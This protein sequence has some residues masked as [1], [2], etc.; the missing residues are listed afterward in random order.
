MKEKI[1][2]RTLSLITVLALIF[3]L[4]AQGV[5]A[6][7]S[8]D[9]NKY[10]Y[11]YVHGLFGW[12]EDEGIDDTLPYWGSASCSLMDEMN[13]RHYESYAAS[14]GPVSSNWDR[15][16][17]LYAQITGTRVDYGAA[18][19]AK[20]H[21][22]RYGRTYS[23]LMIEGWGEPDADGNIKK[24]NLI[25]H[26]FGGAA[27]RTLTALLEYGSA[28]EQAAT[29]PEDI[30]PLFTGGK[31][32][33]INSVTTL[34]APHNGTTLTYIA[35]NMNLAE[36]G[37]AACYIYAGFMGR[38]KLN[39]YVDF[40]LEQFGLTRIPGDDSTPEEVFIKA[41]I[42]VM[43][44]PDNAMF[45]MYPERAEEINE[46]AKPV[47]GVYYFSY[48]YQT[49]RKTLV[50]TQVPMAR[51]LIVLRPMANLIGVY[52]R[53]LDTNYKIDAS[54]LPNDGLVNVISAR[55]PFTDAHEDYTAN[56]ELQT[57]KWYV[58]P[59]HEGDH[60]TVIGMQ[61]TKRQTLKFY[62]ELTDLIESLPVTD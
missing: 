19:S 2:K 52:S 14:V 34:C 35:D 61:C 48:S 39:G 22:S 59:T 8:V 10:P 45:D 17:E 56:A 3:T 6:I 4:A 57:G 23:E 21:H 20:Y 7:G 9:I 50:G 54:W 27:V 62:Y 29:A 42:T 38:S 11:V 37:K 25:G 26:S 58:M 49:T 47:D 12:G 53:N 41:F 24:I 5:S 40:H 13:K 18:H 16:C 31:G 33:Y 51:T 36:L 1:V 28:E 55:Y 30:S 15:V 46:M 32:H 60:G 44:Q 43:S